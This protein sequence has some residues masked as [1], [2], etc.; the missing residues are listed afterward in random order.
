MYVMRSGV[1]M[2]LDTEASC[3][4]STLA[5]GVVVDGNLQSSK[6]I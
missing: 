6:K 3:W 1:G 4:M 2:C 5:D